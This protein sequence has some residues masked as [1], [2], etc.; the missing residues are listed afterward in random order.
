MIQVCNN[1]VT[2]PHVASVDGITTPTYQP[3]RSPRYHPPTTSAYSQRDQYLVM[4]PLNVSLLSSAA[5][6]HCSSPFTSQETNAQ[7]P[8][9]M[10]PH[11]Q[12]LF[13]PDEATLYISLTA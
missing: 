7:A 13:D 8:R 5:R 2:L 11:V 12:V 9:G 3:T 1:N 4:P 10:L 6:T